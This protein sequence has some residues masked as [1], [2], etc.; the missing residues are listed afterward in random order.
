MLKLDVNEAGLSGVRNFK[1]AL[2]S[3]GLLPV[4]ALWFSIRTLFVKISSIG[5][6]KG[7][8]R[9]F[10]VAEKHRDDYFVS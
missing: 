3:D 4:C 10:V 1:I 2:R 5:L 9:Y 6:R 8:G 7:P